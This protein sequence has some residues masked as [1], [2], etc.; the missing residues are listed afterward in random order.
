MTENIKTGRQ[1]SGAR[2]GTLLIFLICGIAL[3]SWAPM[4]PYAK[5]RLHLNDAELG[6]LLLFLGVGAI[7]TMPLTGFFIR[8]FGCRKVMLTAALVLGVTLPS[9]I[10]VNSIPAMAVALFIFGAG[11]GTIDV[12]MNAHAL[13]VQKLHGKHIMSSF[14]GM[15]S[16]GG[17]IGALGLGF[18][19]KTGLSELWSSVCVGCLLMLISALQY[20]RLLSY[21]DEQKLEEKTKKAANLS[22]DSKVNVWLH[23]EVL[24]FGAMCFI[25][26][27]AEGAV[28]D[29]G[30][31][32]L[33]EERHISVEMAGSGFAFFSVAMAVM[34]LT[35]DKL[36]EKFHPEKI[37][38]VGAFLG[39]CGFFLAVCTP[40]LFTS[41]AGFTLLG[42]GVA[43]VIPVL[44]SRGAEIDGIPS[45]RSLPAITTIGYAGQLIGPA[46]LG[47]VAFRTSLP[48]ALGVAGILLL[49]VSFSYW[50]IRKQPVPPA[51]IGSE[52]N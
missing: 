38:M 6:A 23:K 4:V 51:V 29:W 39:A 36:I 10:I 1:V 8:Q 49:V 28:L 31:L 42:L 27:L 24:F 47:F 50:L 3:A 32:F 30:A 15:F 21:A 45:S 34:R 19:I 46:F 7:L 18:L 11:I 52:E 5:D 16:V 25:L 9:L 12:S 2:R 41:L 48:V 17:L 44:F 22:G 26:F 35:G 14:H 37:V 43:N 33:R 20:Q 40:W 13:A